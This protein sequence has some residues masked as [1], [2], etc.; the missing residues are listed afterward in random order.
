MLLRSLHLN[1]S[2]VSQIMEPTVKSTDRELSPLKQALVLIEHLERELSA[3]RTL[4]SEPIAIV[5]MGCRLPGGVSSPESYWRLLCDGIDTVGPIPEDRLP[6]DSV[7]DPNRELPGKIYTRSGSFIGDVSGFDAEFFGISPREAHSL[8]PQHRLLLEVVW[9]TLEHSG[10]PPASLR[11]SSTG[12]FVGI[13]QNDYAQRQLN[14]GQLERITRFDGTGNGF[15]FA[16]GRLSHSLGLHGP[17]ISIDCACSSSLVAVH[18]AC[19]SLRLRECDLALAGGV[20]L[21]LSA[22]VTTFLC[23]TGA[24]ATDGRCK[25]FDA[26]A[27]GFGRGEGCGLVALKRLSDA[28]ASGDFVW[29]TIRG[30]AVNHDGPSSGLTVPN[31]TAQIELLRRALDCGGL[32]PESVSYIEAHGTGTQLGDPIE[33]EALAA[34]YG[35]NRTEKNPIWVASAKTNHGHLEAA[36][37]IAGLI[38]TVLSLHHRKLPPHLHFKKP[39]PHI[40]WDVLPFRIPTALTEWTADRPRIAGISAFGFSG[41]NVHIL[42]EE[43]PTYPEPVTRTNRP[44]LLALSA[45]TSTAVREL[46]ARY[47]AHL[48]QNPELDIADICRTAALGRNHFPHRVAVITDSGSSVC[49]QL[50]AI[51][52][53]E[54]PS[55]TWIGH[56]ETDKLAREHTHAADTLESAAAAY[57]NGREVDWKRWLSKPDGRPVVLPS[58]PFQR[59]RYWIESQK[60]AWQTDIPAMPACSSDSEADQLYEIVWEK[61]KKA[62]TD[63]KRQLLP[64]NKGSLLEYSAA[65]VAPAFGRKDKYSREKD[66][67]VRTWVVVC[68]EQNIGDLI[69]S[70]LRRQGQSCICIRRNSDTALTGCV[71]TSSI[72]GK[73][74]S[75]TL[76]EAVKAPAGCVGFIY[77]ASANSL[78]STPASPDTD[79]IPALQLFQRLRQYNFPQPPRVW[80]VTQ[81]CQYVNGRIREECLPQSMLWGLGR[82]IA[83]EWPD[84]WGGLHDLSEHTDETEINGLVCQL[85]NPNWEQVAWR[86]GEPWIPKLRRKAG[87]VRSTRFTLRSDGAYL[88]TGGS[89]TLGLLVGQWL[90]ERGAGLV[91]LTGRGEPNAKARALAEKFAL[92]GV[93]FWIRRSDCTDLKATTN[94]VKEIQ[95]SGF[96]LRGVFHIAGTGGIRDSIDLDRVDFDNVC[97]AKL[98][99][100]KNLHEATRDQDLDCFV[101]FS[102]IASVWGSKR[103][104]HYC[105]ANHFLDAFASWRSSQHLPSISI[106][107]GPWLGSS[108]VNSDTQQVLEKMGILPF[109]PDDALRA[110]ES[111]IA[112]TNIPQ[113]VAARVDWSCF[114]PLLSTFPRFEFFQQVIE[115][116]LKPVCP[117]PMPT[118]LNSVDG[119]MRREQLY[120]RVASILAELLGYEADR[121]PDAKT[122]FFE[123]GVDSVMAVD[124]Y[125]RLEREFQRALPAT[126][127]FDHPNLV[128]LIDFLEQALFDSA[129]T[130]DTIPKRTDLKGTDSTLEEQ[131]FAHL[132]E[133]RLSQ[134]ES[135]LTRNA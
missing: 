122:G 45:R 82:S 3:A 77:C 27:D 36:A 16:S 111:A 42:I 23:R 47:T 128:S 52:E 30:N 106:N 134:L 13:G 123:L 33:I 58:Y 92:S 96:A 119:K 105:A 11:N 49:D 68:D 41:T 135:L 73:Q 62:H 67:S 31:T 79:C 86:N 104:A 20:Q 131:S 48:E 43:A 120:D 28:V 10:I 102:S 32:K 55:Q 113:M 22:E 35:H 121:L 112:E 53:G 66:S 110:L 93:T 124:F 24:L 81:A 117:I 4:A 38:K 18:L 54:L 95:T 132:V 26:D 130:L 9:E 83:L 115:N 100:A 126:I 37:G 71:G 101:L 114:A 59:K 129:E 94:L 63:R 51:A 78:V 7:Y 85:L 44:S 103:Q 99:G 109:S 2:F 107:W 56:I 75:D 127:A 91:V 125:R 12:V 21:I 25:A 118:R 5:G 76:R 97:R 61:A 57:V 29:A 87:S 133:E 8:D 50:H 60:L 1:M 34:V 14:G 88:I 19:Q 84:L 46:A 6:T 40:P 72:S 90:A 74:F 80:L 70:E 89:G 64:A 17:S 108:L 39:N 116:E 69:A 98:E 15:C 65:P